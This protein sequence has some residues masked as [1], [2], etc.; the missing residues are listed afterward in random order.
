MVVVPLPEIDTCDEGLMAEVIMEAADVSG[1]RRET[2]SLLEGI[3]GKH[4]GAQPRRKA[5]KTSVQLE[6]RMRLGEYARKTIWYSVRYRGTSGSSWRQR[7]GLNLSHRGSAAKSQNSGDRDSHG[8]RENMSHG[9]EVESDGVTIA[10]QRL[11]V[12]RD[13]QGWTLNVESQS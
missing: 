13:G 8:T 7:R 9:I 11:L 3:F 4:K 12:E 2:A 1:Y 10:I 5:L 6:S